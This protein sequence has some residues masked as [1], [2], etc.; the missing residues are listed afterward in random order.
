MSQGALN[1]RRN[2]LVLSVLLSATCA[3]AQTFTAT[4]TEVDAF[5]V[6]DAN[7]DG[8]LDRSEFKVFVRGMARAGQSTA[9]TIRTFGAYGF[10]FGIV[11]KD[12]DGFASPEEMRAADNDFRA[13]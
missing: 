9:R 2:I 12:K 3:Y 5:V 1:M 11:D 13:E 7:R 6:A 4:D 10:A 8:R